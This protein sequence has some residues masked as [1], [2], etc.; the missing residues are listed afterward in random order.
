[1]LQGKKTYQFSPVHAYNGMA[2]FTITSL[3]L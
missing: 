1:M 2:V 3:L